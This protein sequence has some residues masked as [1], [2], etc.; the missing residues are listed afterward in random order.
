[1]VQW[2]TAHVTVNLPEDLYERIKKH[3]EIKWAAVAREAMISYLEMI[4]G[5][6]GKGTEK[7]TI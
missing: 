2:L 7:K 4:E 3:K 6:K 1:M 5:A